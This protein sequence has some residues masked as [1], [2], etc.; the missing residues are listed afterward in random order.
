[1]P[2]GRFFEERIFAPLAMRES[3]FVV[4][5]DQLGRLAQPFATDPATGEKISLID[6]TA[7]P[8]YESGG[9]GGVST[10]DDYIRFA[11]MLLNGGRLDG[12]RL[13]SRTTAAFMAS[14][15]LGRISDTMRAPG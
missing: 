1:M 11:Q 3:G 2:L 5:K 7:P 10:T 15:H 13:L 4:P 6:V 8:K 12:A 14:D 9:G